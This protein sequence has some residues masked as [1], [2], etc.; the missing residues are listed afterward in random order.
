M[1]SEKLLREALHATREWLHHLDF[2]VRNEAEFSHLFYHHLLLATLT[3]GCSPSCVRSEIK[4]HHAV[5]GRQRIAA[6]IDFGI[7]SSDASSDT[8]DSLIE[9]KSWIRNNQIKG[10]LT[11]NASTSKR[12]QC[13]ADAQRLIQLQ[14]QGRCRRAALL[15]FEQGSSHLRRL[16]LGELA[17][18]GI[19]AEEHWIDVGRASLGRRKEHLGLLWLTSASESP[20]QDR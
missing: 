11:P 20:G 19:V 1:V 12:R 16:I 15:V 17:G 5:D 7:A 2:S 18:C 3:N 6:S 8:F 10:A 9:V 4:Y 14:R 13:A